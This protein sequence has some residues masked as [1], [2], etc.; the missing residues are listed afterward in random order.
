MLEVGD[1]ANEG[2]RAHVERHR[3]PFPRIDPPKSIDL[4]RN[5]EE[6]FKL[7]RSQWMNFSTLTRLNEETEEYQ[8][9]LLLYTVGDSCAKIF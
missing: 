4:S 7:Y 6:N 9:A 2:D 1:G 5:R 3:R 8:I